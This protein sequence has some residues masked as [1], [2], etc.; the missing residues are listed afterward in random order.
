MAGV[1]REVGRLRTSVIWAVT[2]MSASSADVAGLPR[3]VPSSRPQRCAP[4]PLAS[5][6]PTVSCDDVWAGGLHEPSGRGVARES[7]G[8]WTRSGRVHWA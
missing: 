6:V 7:G 1:V 4:T 8:P 2:R 5:G 3:I